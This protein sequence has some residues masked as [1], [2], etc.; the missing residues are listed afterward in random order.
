MTAIILGIT[1]E[2]VESTWDAVFDLLNWV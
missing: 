2:R 1:V